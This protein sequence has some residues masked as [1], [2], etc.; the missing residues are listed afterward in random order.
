ETV[1]P[2]KLG[3]GGGDGRVPILRPGHVEMVVGR[4]LAEAAGGFAAA[5]VE[6]VADHDL[7]PASIISRAVS[8]PMPRAAPE[9]SA[10]LPSSRF[11]HP[12]RFQRKIHNEA[13]RQ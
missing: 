10:T 4:A 8:A 3:G 6:H 13:V 1:E 12:S 11:I 7:A 2:A 5:L 9:I